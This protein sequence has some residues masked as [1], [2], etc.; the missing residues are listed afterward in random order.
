[1][2]NKIITTI[3]PIKLR[4]LQ[5]GQQRAIVSPKQWRQQKANVQAVA[6]RSFELLKHKFLK[7]IGKSMMHYANFQENATTLEQIDNIVKSAYKKAYMLGLKS[8]GVT[9]YQHNLS[10]KKVTLPALEP[11]EAY[12]LN[13]TVIE[14]VVN[15]AHA[16]HNGVDYLLQQIE[17]DLFF[18]Y[19][20]GRLIG[21]PIYSFVYFNCDTPTAQCHDLRDKSPWPV[22]LIT[23]IPVCCRFKII[24]KT[25]LEYRERLLEF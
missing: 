12:W 3:P 16:L 17:I 14:K 11:K 7:K 9:L 8:S 25:A 19:Q 21:A 18:F 24:P 5:L 4:K 10:L 13:Q 23:E 6:G 2:I 15:L 1:M 20:Q 22:E